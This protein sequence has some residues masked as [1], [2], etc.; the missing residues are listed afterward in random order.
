MSPVLPQLRGLARTETGASAAEYGL[1]ISGIAAVLIVI[2]LAFGGQVKGLF[3]NTCS[4]V[5]TQGAATSA[6]C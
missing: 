6:T 1:L 4:S 5:K 2:V 3:D